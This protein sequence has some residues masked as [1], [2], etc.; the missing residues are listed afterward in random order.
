MRGKL[1]KAQRRVLGYLCDNGPTDLWPT[2]VLPSR[3]PLRDLE[4]LGFVE[5]LNRLNPGLVVHA[6]TPAG[7]AALQQQEGS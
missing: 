2:D 5:R 6:A 7:R 3:K 1:T 4:A